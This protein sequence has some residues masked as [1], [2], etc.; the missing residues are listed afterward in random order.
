M[1]HKHCLTQPSALH[2]EV[3]HPEA[4][5][6]EHTPPSAAPTPPTSP[7]AWPPDPPFLL[8]QHPNRRAATSLSRTARESAQSSICLCAAP[9][10]RIAPTPSLSPRRGCTFG[11]RDPRGRQATTG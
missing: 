1:L 4:Q 8:D 7:V 6:L 3:P 5:R 10:G 9:G 11:A 2:T